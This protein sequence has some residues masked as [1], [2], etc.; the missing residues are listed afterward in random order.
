VLQL[1][2]DPDAA[3]VSA[4]AMAGG[5]ALARHYCAEMLRLNGT[6]NIPAH[7]LHASALL[8]WWQS[9]GCAEMHLARI[10]QWGPNALR[11]AGTA[12]AA[13]LVL[14]EH[15]HAIAMK[16]GAVVDGAKRREAWRLVD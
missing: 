14:V 3:E 1:Y 15:G 16:A 6:A 9:V 12:R 8:N 4:I 10:Y 7:L 5:I 2:A 11:N 13:M